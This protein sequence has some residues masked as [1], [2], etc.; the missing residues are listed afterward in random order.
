[1]LALEGWLSKRGANEIIVDMTMLTSIE[2]FQEHLMNRYN[3]LSLM[4]VMKVYNIL[5]K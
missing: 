4:D 3:G 1:M 2:N 5:S